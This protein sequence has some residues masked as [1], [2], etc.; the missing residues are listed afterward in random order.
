MTVLSVKVKDKLQEIV[1]RKRA[2][3]E[4]V[5][6][7]EQQIRGNYVPFAGYIWKIWTNSDKNPILFHFLPIAFGCQRALQEIA[8]F[9]EQQ[10]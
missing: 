10:I 6:F 9:K 4:I 2:L 5:T 7:K 3:H 1:L 8:T